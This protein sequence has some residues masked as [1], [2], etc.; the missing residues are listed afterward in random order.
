[1]VKKGQTWTWTI[2]WEPKYEPDATS[3]AIRVG[4]KWRRRD[5]AIV[6]IVECD[7]SDV[8]PFKSS[9]GEWYTSSGHFDA[10]TSLTPYDLVELI[11][12]AG[13]TDGK[14]DDGTRR[15]TSI[16]RTIDL[17]GEHI[18]DAIAND[19]TAWWNRPSEGTN[20]VQITPLP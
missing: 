10:D 3:P 8:F 16:T 5:G 1:M 20:W 17:N 6:E 11:A 15:F 2:Y 13:D 4:Q 19:G 7:N 9:D 18:L 12:D 14:A